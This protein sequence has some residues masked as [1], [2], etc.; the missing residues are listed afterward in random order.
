MT[1]PAVWRIERAGFVA[2]ALPLAAAALLWLGTAPA[3][4]HA[5]P[6]L[7]VV[8][9]SVPR[10]LQLVLD[11]RAL[12]ILSP[13]LRGDTAGEIYRLDL[14]GDMPVDL[15][16]QPRIRIP[17]V[18]SRV[19]TLGSL[20]INPR[21]RELFLGEEN[22]TRVYRLTRDEQMSLYATGLH[23]LGG[24]STLA[25]DRAGNLIVVDHADPLLSQNDERT[26]P[27][28]EQFREEDYRGPLVFR[29]AADSV[30][31]VPRHL[32]GVAPLFP[33]AWGGKSGG[34]HLP[35]LISVAPRGSDDLVF[36]TSSGDLYRLG[37]DGALALFAGL[38]RGQYTR[39][40]MIAAPDGTVFVSGGFQV[41]S[42][43][44]VSPDGT[45]VA[46]VASRLGDPQ[47]IALDSQG[48][49]YLAESALH[50]IV[51]IRPL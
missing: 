6:G 14:G 41:G 26:P 7:E 17:F 24:G 40:N 47:G 9:T 30:I 38:P 51:R 45:A 25:F 32:D 29:L 49:L 3:R 4:L 1:G 36:L 21:T 8:A 31:P 13:G 16:G 37:A 35:R 27:G 39:A 34:A 10:P 15:S 44:R 2:L 42:V 22:G 20:A 48:N 19:A 33:R 50:R 43:F 12:V 18:D 23:R 28:L 5:S 46:L 11:G